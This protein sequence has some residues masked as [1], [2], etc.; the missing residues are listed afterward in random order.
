MSGDDLY[1]QFDSTFF[2]KTRLS[3]ITI[4]YREEKVSF[5]RFKNVIGGSDGA[6]YTHL[7]KL[8]DG[9][10]IKSKKEIASDSVQTV[11]TLTGQG[12]KMF[13]KYLGFLETILVRKK[14]EETK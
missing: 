5:N 12:K 14:E 4:L 8:I 6:I 7:K 3:M 9:G 2:E 1:T 13:Q 11:Y 10:Y